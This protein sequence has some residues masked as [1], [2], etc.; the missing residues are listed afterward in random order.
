M[1]TL[2]RIEDKLDRVAES[3]AGLDA[4]AKQVDKAV[5][6]LQTEVKPI[7]EHVQRI[8]GMAALVAF[9]VAVLEAIHL[10]G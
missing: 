3:L 7:R 6:D 5:G 8:K 10:W 9:G 2:G 4:W 1:E